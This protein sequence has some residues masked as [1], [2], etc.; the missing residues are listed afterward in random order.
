MHQHIKMLRNC[1]ENEKIWLNHKNTILDTAT[2]S[3]SA[4]LDLFLFDSLAKVPH[5]NVTF[6]HIANQP[7]F[8]IS[9]CL[10]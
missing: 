8:G 1:R 9:E 2:V 7:G 6:N 5:C 10:L 3:L 4:A